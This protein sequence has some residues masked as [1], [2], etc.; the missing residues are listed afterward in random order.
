MLRFEGVDSSCKVWL[1][2]ELL[3]TSRGSRLPIEFDV[4]LAAGRNVLAVRVHQW[5][6]GSYLEDQDMWWMSGDLPR[7]QVFPRPRI[8]DVF[9]HADYEAGTGTLTVDAPGTV[10]VPELGSTSPAARRSRPQVEPWSAE[11][12]R[13]YDATVEH[14]GETVSLRIGFRRVEIKDGLLQVNGTPILLQGRQP[15]RVRPG[16]RPHGL[17]GDH[18]PRHRADEDAQRQRGAHVATTRR[19]RASSSSATSTGST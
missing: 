8:E 15:P 6:S 13:L 3:G 17:R 5:S 11:V 19:T 14:E 1:N 4:T 9:V 18:A 7:R 12:P 2:G 10:S 16:A